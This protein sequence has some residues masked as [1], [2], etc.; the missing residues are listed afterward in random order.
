MTSP[1]TTFPLLKC[2]KI[3]LRT[4]TGG[5][6]MQQKPIEGYINSTQEHTLKDS[7][8]E[9]KKKSPKYFSLQGAALYSQVFQ[10]KANLR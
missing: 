4:S 8:M 10:H 1:I 2:H 6:T 7:K 9:K 5:K 3:H